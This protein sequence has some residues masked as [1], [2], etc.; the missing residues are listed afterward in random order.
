MGNK[1]ILCIWNGFGYEFR[2][3]T[4]IFSLLIPYPCFEIEENL[5][6]YPNSV[7]AGKINQIGFGTDGYVCIYFVVMPTL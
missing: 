3:D 5:N 7:K 4:Y 6:T 2:M 1:L